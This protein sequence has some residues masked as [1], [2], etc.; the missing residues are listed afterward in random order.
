MKLDRAMIRKWKENESL[1]REIKNKDKKYRKNRLGGIKKTMSEEEEE[2][3]C[4]F[5]KEAR[6]NKKV[7]GTKSVVCFAE[8]INS[9]FKN[10][11]IHTQ[12]MWCYRL[13]KHHGFFIRKIR[14]VGQQIP[15]NINSLKESF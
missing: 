9:S 15:E 10:K 3:I 11:S 1:L 2:K 13:N 8:N 12:L 6:E 5:I 4:K 14:H 7:I